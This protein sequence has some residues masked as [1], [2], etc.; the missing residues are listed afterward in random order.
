M[1]LRFQIGGRAR[2]RLKWRTACFAAAIVGLTAFGMPVRT[3]RKPE[4]TE[5]FRR[6]FATDEFEPKTFGPA[7]WLEGGSAYTT[8]EASSAVAGA[9]D[10][11]RYA[12]AGGER[13]VLVSASQLTPAGA[14]AALAKIIERSA[15]FPSGMIRSTWLALPAYHDVRL[16]GRR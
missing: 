14:K 8:M 11:V 1:T 3:Q 16:N 6:M 10:I 13:S 2:L 7:K 5:L 9:K 4:T 12:T 15:Y